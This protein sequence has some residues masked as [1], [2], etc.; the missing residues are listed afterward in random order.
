M[1]LIEQARVDAKMI[2]NSGGFELPCLFVNGET[3]I[4]AN[5]I[6]IRRTDTIEYDDGSKKHSPFSS[7]LVDYDIFNFTNKYVSLKG[8]TVQVDG[9][10]YSIEESLPNRTLGLIQCNLRDQNG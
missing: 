5:A 8:W 2:V 9:G 6:F 3:E 4:E 10:T 1:S 7:I